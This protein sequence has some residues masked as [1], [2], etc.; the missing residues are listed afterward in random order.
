MY[1][2]GRGVVIKEKG[3]IQR[4]PAWDTRTDTLVV[5]G[6]VCALRGLEGERAL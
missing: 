5:G 1:D 6:G 4:P 3:L 2:G